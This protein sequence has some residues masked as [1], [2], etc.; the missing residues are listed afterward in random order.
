M[1]PD[2]YFIAAGAAQFEPGKEMSWAGVRAR[3]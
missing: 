2:D 3:E 1:K